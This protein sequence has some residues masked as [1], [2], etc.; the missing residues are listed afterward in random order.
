VVPMTLRYGGRPLMFSKDGKKVL[1]EEN[2][3]NKKLFW[4]DKKQETQ[5]C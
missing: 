4:Y 2:G 5:N 3:L 1:M